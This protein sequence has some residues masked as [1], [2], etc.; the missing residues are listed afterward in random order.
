M[1]RAKRTSTIK[2]SGNQFA[3]ALR[4]AS[5]ILKDHGT[6]GETHVC[7]KNNWVTAYNGVLAVG[8]KCDSDLFACPQIKLAIEALSKCGQNIAITQLDA[9]RLSIKSDRF[10]AIIPC[11][12]LSLLEPPVPDPSIAVIGDNLKTAFEIAGL[13][14][15]DNAQTIYGASVLMNGQSL[16]SSL[17]GQMIIE[18]WHGIDLP[19]GLAI[20]K[21]LIAPLSKI[22]KKL[23]GFGFSTWSVTFYFED[24]SWIKSQLYSEQWPDIHRVFDCVA[25]VQ[26]FPADFWSAL[27]AVAPF[28]EAL[29]YFCEGRLRSHAAEG[30]GAEFELPGLIGGPIYPARQLAALRSWATHVD[31]QA[32]GANGPV[33]YAVGKQAR[34]VIAGVRGE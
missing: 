23:V 6:V 26:Q 10:K 21:A 19:T 22:N 9:N 5:L 31:F 28:S 3:D 4:F 27:D 14:Q 29:A 25:N 13:L 17:S 12:N 16:I 15:T 33:L 1:T 32:H 7:I 30:V 18:Y 24:E 11:V 2:P 8:H 34:A 20:P